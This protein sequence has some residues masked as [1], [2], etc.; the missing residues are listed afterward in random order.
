M[1]KIFTILNQLKKK[2]KNCKD[3][4]R[5][6]NAIVLEGYADCWESYVINS[7]I[8]LWTVR[9][10]GTG[11]AG[12]THGCK[13][14]ILLIF[15]ILAWIREWYRALNHSWSAISSWWLLVEGQPILFRDTVSHLLP[16][17]QWTTPHWSAYGKN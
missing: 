14:G 13:C 17:L 8:Q 5:W 3:D 16:I 4:P 6:L 12:Y 10:H 15:D 2:I 11:L 1:E 7:L 9:N